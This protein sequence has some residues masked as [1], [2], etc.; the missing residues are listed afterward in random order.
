ML[1]KLL[2]C[3]DVI[4]CLLS[5]SCTSTKAP[6]PKESHVIEVPGQL[7]TGGVLLPNQ[8]L[9]HPVGKQIQVGDFPAS[10]AMHPGGRYA[11]VLH[12]G[13]GPHEVAIIDVKDGR[14]V[15]RASIEESF[16]GIHFS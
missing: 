2:L 1:H 3:L 12:C 5:S 11:A 10:M 16:Y 13:Y 7:A 9:L 8:W 4:G 15:S 14:L 6:A